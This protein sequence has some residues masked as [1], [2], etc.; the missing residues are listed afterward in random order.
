MSRFNEVTAKLKEMYKGTEAQK[1]AL[2]SNLKKWARANRSTKDTGKLHA[3]NS[4]L[5]DLG[6]I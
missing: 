1:D 2:V 6:C 5:A 3:I 4:F